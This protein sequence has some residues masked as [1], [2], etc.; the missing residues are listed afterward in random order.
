MIGCYYCKNFVNSNNEKNAVYFCSNY[1]FEICTNNASIFHRIS[2]KNHIITF[3]ICYYCCS[4]INR[5]TPTFHYNDHTFCSS[6]CRKL[7]MQNH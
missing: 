6:G 1:C 3:K 4:K 2:D 5:N 7:F